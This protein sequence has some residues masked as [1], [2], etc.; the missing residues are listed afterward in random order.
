MVRTTLLIL[1]V[2]L[3]TACKS[4]DSSTTATIGQR[5]MANNAV[6]YNGYTVNVPTGYVSIY[7]ADYPWSTSQLELIERLKSGDQRERDARMNN[8]YVVDAASFL[9]PSNLSVIRVVSAEMRN[10]GKPFAQWNQRESDL[11]LNW[12]IDDMSRKEG[13]DYRG[14]IQKFNDYDGVLLSGFYQNETDLQA[15]ARIV[16][17]GKLREV[18]VIQGARP[19]RGLD[20]ITQDV[21]ETA[22]SI[23]L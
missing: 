8:L 12:Y 13:Y 16:M 20:N 3:L 21:R 18:F 1:S 14:G 15:G 9:N 22:E 23:Q 6:G 4:D 7:D 11:Y 19:N 5:S 17:L 2:I 10:T